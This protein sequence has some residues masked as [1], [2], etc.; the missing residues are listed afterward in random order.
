MSETCQGTAYDAAQMDAL[1]SQALTSA[2][3]APGMQLDRRRLVVKMTASQAQAGEIEVQ[4]RA[5][6]VF[7]CTDQQQ[8]ALARLLAGKRV[9]E[10]IG[11]LEQQAGV[12]RVSINVS[13][14]DA[15]TL[16]AESGRIQVLCLAPSNERS[17]LS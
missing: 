15:G 4:A 5:L 10:A 16:P 9:G 13:G 14:T 6:L 12:A 11:L 1:L 2:H 7:Q 8:R 17:S 3:P